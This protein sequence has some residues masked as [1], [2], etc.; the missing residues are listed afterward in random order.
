MARVCWQRE[1]GEAPRVHGELPDH[2]QAF[3]GG[4]LGAEVVPGLRAQGELAYRP[5][6]PIR[7]ASRVAHVRIVAGER[8]LRM[9]Q[10][11]A[12]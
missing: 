3:L 5:A 9:E 11:W 4:G 6:A 2:F 12:L 10:D 8:H 1:P 7:L